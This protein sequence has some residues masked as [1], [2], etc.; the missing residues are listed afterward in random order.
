[1]IKLCPGGSATVIWLHTCMQVG[2]CVNVCEVVC[3]LGRLVDL[4]SAGTAVP[5]PGLQQ[6]QC[7]RI[8]A[9]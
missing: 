5:I 1:M 4:I 6:L 9:L 3:V 7:G 8:R 2:K